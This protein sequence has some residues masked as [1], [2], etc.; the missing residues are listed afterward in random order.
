MN[1]PRTEKELKRSINRYIVAGLATVVIF[2]GGLGGLAMT[3]E[4]SG[5]V[6]AGGTI[7]VDSNVK[8]IQHPTGGVVGAILV[9]EGDRVKRGDTLVRLDETT[10]R[11][12]LAIV[13]QGV[14]EAVARVSRLEAERDGKAQIS[15]PEI[16]VKGNNEEKIKRLMEGETSLFNFRTQVRD[17][18]KSQLRERIAQLVDEV[19]G[20][21]QQLDAK[22][23]E[24]AL[25]DADLEYVRPLYDKKLVSRDRISQLERSAI[26]VQ[27]AIGQLKA[28]IASAKGRSSEIELQI[29]QIDQDL[30][31]EVADDLRETQAKLAELYERQRVAE[32]Q[33][34]R[35]ELRSPQDG[36]VHELKI[37][38]E[39]GVIQPGEI[40]MSIVP[41]A[42]DLTI[43]AQVHPQDIDQIHPGQSTGVRLSA[44]SHGTTPELT[45]TLRNV[46]PDLSVDQRSGIGYYSA[47][48]VL[49]KEEVARLKGLT[50]QPGMPAELFFATGERTMMSY[51][52]KPLA[53]QIRRAFRE[54][55]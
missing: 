3:T 47:Y 55:E 17:G 32:D 18:Q 5:A 36:I 30:R 16:L 48:V 25:I 22:T 31:S 6:I 42:D 24:A 33:L 12:S 53:D 29:L 49:P 1:A 26:E 44:F 11:A 41:I 35:I 13:S 23:K 39:G 2:V 20:L 4:I 14:N 10:V 43:V 37:H 34:Q 54:G 21:G 52:V 28:S 38:T 45:G 50:L 40:L 27:G 9:R 15:F 7:V 8:K 51:L 19:D 46:S